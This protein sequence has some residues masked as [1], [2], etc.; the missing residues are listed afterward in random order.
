MS[1]DALTLLTLALMALG[2]YATRISG[3]ILVER[4]SFAGRKKA[5]R[6]W[7]PSSLAAGT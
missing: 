1:L 7:W 5:A 2:T 3:I 6:R 4:L